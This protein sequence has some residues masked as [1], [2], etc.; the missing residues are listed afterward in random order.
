MEI[1]LPVSEPAKTLES[2]ISL[3][4]DKDVPALCEQ[5]VAQLKAY[6]DSRPLK[7]T[8]SALFTVVPSTAQIQWHHARAKYIGKFNTGREPTKRG[9]KAGENTWVMWNH[10]FNGNALVVLRVHT[11]PRATGETEDSVRKE[12][13]E[14]LKGILLAAETEAAEWGLKSVVVWNPEVEMQEAYKRV[15]NWKN[16][17]V[18]ERPDD[19][20]PSLRWTPKEGREGDFTD[21]TVWIAN[22]KFAWE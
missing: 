15:E 13:V 19:S 21:K 3:V 10:D 17:Q 5:D 2:G 16:V 1:N 7:P 11:P 22:E 20:V 6:F 12:V 14:G 8:E 18:E 4:V 9:A